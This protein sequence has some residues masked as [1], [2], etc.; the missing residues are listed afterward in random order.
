[1]RGKPASEDLSA[2]TGRITPAHAGKTRRAAGASLTRT[3]HPRACGENRDCIAEDIPDHGSPPRMRG[4]RARVFGGSSYRR[5]TPAHAGKTLYINFIYY[6]HS[7]HPRACGENCRDVVMQHSTS[8]SPPRMRGKPLS[9][10]SWIRGTRITPAH[11]GK[12]PMLYGGCSCNADHPRAC[13]ENEIPLDGVTEQ[14]GSPPRMRGKQL[15]ATEFLDELR[16]TPAHA[17]KTG[18]RRAK[19]GRPADHPRA[20]GENTVLIHLPADEAGSPPRMRGKL[21]SAVIGLPD[22]R[23]TP[24]HAGKTPSSHFPHLT[25]S[26][27]PRACGE[28]SPPHPESLPLRGS[29]PRMR[30]KRH[31]VHPSAHIDRI[32]PAH[33]GKTPVRPSRPRTES[34]HPRA[35]GENT[36]ARIMDG[37]VVG[38]PPRM[39]GKP[40]TK[41]VHYEK[42]RITPA[43]AGKT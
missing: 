3:D 2:L 6:V 42:P 31:D 39:R 8:G 36:G 28:N 14:G 21:I 15:G 38:S 11:A 35:C 4:K 24:A 23:I 19:S 5:I 12:T 10:F 37:D 26:D 1:M 30:G 34:D 40:H 25:Q 22:K 41:G 13:G 9:C 29:P 33:A 27:H 32:T 7:D 17:G 20:C 43:H 16:I 18:R